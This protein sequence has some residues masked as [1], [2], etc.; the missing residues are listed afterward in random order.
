MYKNG[1]LTKNKIYLIITMIFY[2][3]SYFFKWDL[4]YKISFEIITV[5][6]IIFFKSVIHQQNY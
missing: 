3:V 2:Y 4:F 5:L 1:D 6:K